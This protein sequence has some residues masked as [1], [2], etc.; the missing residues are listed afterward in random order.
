MRRF[1]RF[2]EGGEHLGA[3]GGAHS[4]SAANAARISSPVAA[5]VHHR[6]EFLDL[7]SGRCEQIDEARR[8]PA[9]IERALEPRVGPRAP[10]ADADDLAPGDEHLARTAAV[11]AHERRPNGAHQ[12]STMHLGRVDIQLRERVRPCVADPP[13]G[14]AGVAVPESVGARHEHVD[15]EDF[16]GNHEDRAAAAL[17]PDHLD[18]VRRGRAPIDYRFVL[19]QAEHQRR[20]IDLEEPD[21]AL[22]RVGHR[23]RVERRRRAAGM[24]DPPIHARTIAR[25]TI[26]GYRLMMGAARSIDNA[27]R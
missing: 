14:L 17:A 8:V 16:A 7:R 24:F 5:H 26:D 22:G 2:P 12:M 19:A 13:R 15:P 21:G 25:R 10:L 9:A 4:G 27:G 23:Q 3:P 11:E 20:A 1:A 6:R 18:A